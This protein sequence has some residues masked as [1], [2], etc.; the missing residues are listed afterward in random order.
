MLEQQQGLQQL[1]IV[2][3]TKIRFCKS[4]KSRKRR[5]QII[6]ARNSFK[7]NP[8][9]GG[10]TLLDPKNYTTLKIDQDLLDARKSSSL[11]DI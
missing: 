9:N 1:L 3:R 10:K 8:Y 11:Q 7:I 4:E 2:V 5:W 6:K